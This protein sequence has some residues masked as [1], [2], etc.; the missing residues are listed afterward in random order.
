MGVRHR[1]EHLSDPLMQSPIN[2]GILI[3]AKTAFFFI[4]SLC[5]MEFYFP[6]YTSEL[7]PKANFQ[8]RATPILLT[9]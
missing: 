5:K 7:Q 8:I 6:F 9:N 4:P 3:L 2:N 1:W